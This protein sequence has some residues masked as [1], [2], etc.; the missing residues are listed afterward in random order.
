MDIRVQEI[1]SVKITSLMQIKVQFPRGKEGTSLTQ[2]DP[3]NN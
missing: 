2:K 3:K 1:G